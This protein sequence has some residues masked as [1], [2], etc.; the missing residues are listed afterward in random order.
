G[1]YRLSRAFLE[2]AVAVVED[3]EIIPERSPRKAVGYH[4]V[5]AHA[6]SGVAVELG[7]REVDGDACGAGFVGSVFFGH[8]HAVQ[9]VDD[10]IR[11][12]AD[13]CIPTGF[14][15]D[16]LDEVPQVNIRG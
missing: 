1:D 7:V 6:S 15:V 11:G 16:Q 2:G 3:Q 8:Q 10:V 9:R 14:L 12:L 5:R 4:G 13:G